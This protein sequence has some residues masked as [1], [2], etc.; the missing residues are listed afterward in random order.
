MDPEIDTGR[1]FSQEFF[2]HLK[3]GPGDLKGKLNVE[4]IPMSI[5]EEKNCMHCEEIDIWVIRMVEDK[6]ET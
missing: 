5:L 6:D 1:D 3:E 2:D 4:T